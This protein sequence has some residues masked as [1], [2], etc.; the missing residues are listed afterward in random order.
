MFKFTGIVMCLAPFGVGPRSRDHRPNG[1]G[2]LWNLGN[3]SA[4]LWRL[5]G[6]HRLVLVPVMLIARSR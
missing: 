6:V 2:I 5:G 4:P 3:W 1:L